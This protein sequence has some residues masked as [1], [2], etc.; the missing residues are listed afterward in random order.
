MPAPNP[1]DPPRI[2]GPPILAEED[3]N[4]FFPDDGLSLRNAI[5]ALDLVFGAPARSIQAG[6]L[7]ARRQ[8]PLVEI[9]DDVGRQLLGFGDEGFGQGEIASGLKV[10]EEVGLV[11]DRE[12][13]GNVIAGA[14]VDFLT[15]VLAFNLVGAARRFAGAPAT[16]MAD[17]VS[18]DIRVRPFR[19]P[20]VKA[21]ARESRIFKS[22]VLDSLTTRQLGELVRQV[23][24]SIPVSRPGRKVSREKVLQ[25]LHR[26][27][28]R[29][30]F[31][32][33]HVRVDRSPTK[34]QQA[35]IN[36]TATQLGQAASAMQRSLS[37]F[38]DGISPEVIRV[39]DFKV[40][41]LLGSERP[42]NY[43]DVKFPSSPV[44]KRVLPANEYQP[45]YTDL[46]LKGRESKPGLA[47]LIPSFMNP[48][49]HRNL[50]RRTG[51]M[52]P[53]VR[54]VARLQQALREDF[55]ELNKLAGEIGLEARSD[56]ARMLG[57]SIENPELY[58]RLTAQERLF[59]RKVDA[60]EKRIA[61]RLKEDG[62]PLLDEEFFI[63]NYFHH[64]RTDIRRPAQRAFEV[65]MEKGWR[66]RFD[67]D[68]P[69]HLKVGFT[70]KRTEDSKNL[71]YDIIESVKAYILAANRKLHLEPLANEVGPDLRALNRRGS[72]NL[73]DSAR[74]AIA[75]AFG[76]YGRFDG[77]F[78]DLVERLPVPE[79]ALRTATGGIISK[80]HYS[81]ATRLSVAINTAAMRA[82]LGLSPRTTILQFFQ[83]AVN[84]SLELGFW[85]ALKG[86]MRQVN[87]VGRPIPRAAF[88]EVPIWNGF[89]KSLDQE[90]APLFGKQRRAFDRIDQ[91][92]FAGIQGADNL[93]RGSAFWG[94]YSMAK[95]VGLS[96]EAA[97]AM[98]IRVS[99]ETQFIYGKLA[100]SSARLNP[101]GRVLLQFTSYATKQLSFLAQKFRRDPGTN[102]LRFLA[103]TGSLSRSWGQ[104][105]DLE[106]D[107]VP[108][109]PGDAL[110]L[111]NIQRWNQLPIGESVDA[112]VDFAKVALQETAGVAKDGMVI[113]PQVASENLQR[114]ILRAWVPAG[115]MVDRIA[116]FAPTFFQEEQLSPD[117]PEP[118]RQVYELARRVASG[119]GLTEGE[120]KFLLTRTGAVGQE[121]DRFGR[122]IANMKGDRALLGMMGFRTK[123]AA[124]ERQQAKD[125]TF[126]IER[127]N[128][129]RGRLLREAV[130]AHMNGRDPSVFLIQAQDVSLASS[131]SI[132]EGFRQR[133]E[134]RRLTRLERIRKR[135]PRIL[136]LTP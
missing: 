20:I 7:G 44:L 125:L 60:F 62:T 64:R 88:K 86:F 9:M 72:Q 18:K 3:P 130:R 84:N 102:F 57:K 99:N 48:F 34:I 13:L 74:D 109:T 92:L 111:V 19:E 113:D 116:R 83:L 132:M 28:D 94:G 134:N 30:D 135:R 43:F 112:L 11:K 89:M 12:N 58:A 106:R 53:V 124:L 96:D 95:R 10:L 2:F 100:T 85:D 81:N 71:D 108:M 119:V 51:I 118:V 69:D 45:G 90:F 32:D 80:E 67:H 41:K 17:L 126:Q 36:P 54:R 78:D 97:K 42:A 5:G 31:E 29:F 25:R 38:L 39:V 21:T 120:R 22:R 52:E 129:Q 40:G 66:L 47:A 82:R 104:Q 127:I 46:V 123:D 68:I 8:E 59:L 131:A 98:G 35:L 1:L 50:L 101:M 37:G 14:G 105:I 27:I 70:M 114:A 15:D 128:A 77:A 33:L 16:R 79:W 93:N 56:R 103:M 75:A 110:N 115:T 73:Y 55:D 122:K 107:L 6:F 136:E 65:E 117:T 23:E 49:D 4:R 26:A 63:P 133:L 87:P 76:Q 91:V 121:V 61:G 24:G